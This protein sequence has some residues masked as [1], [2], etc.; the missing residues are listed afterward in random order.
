MPDIEEIKDAP[1]KKE[2]LFKRK[3]K[4]LRISALFLGV[5]LLLAASILYAWH[6]YRVSPPYVDPERFPIRGIDVSS[7]NGMIDFK[8]VAADGIEFVWIK[9]SEGETFRDNNFILNF[10]KATQ[11]G[12]KT[13]AYHFFR[14]DRDGVAQARNFIRSVA[15]RCLDLGM[16]IDVEETGNAGGVPHDS[17]II[18]LRDMIEYLNVAGVRPIL[19]SNRAGFDKYIYDEFRDLP[20][21]ICQFTDNSRSGDWLYWQF[22]HHGHVAGVKTEVDLDVYSGSREDWEYMLDNMPPTLLLPR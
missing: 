19:Y 3:K 17:I 1:A 10:Q 9:A 11:A 6:E 22:Y 8:A 12:L 20:L 21:W 13:G 15:G 18:R 7:H 4:E 16:A 2:S 5:S 14:F